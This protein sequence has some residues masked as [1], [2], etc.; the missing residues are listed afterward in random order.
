VTSGAEFFAVESALPELE[1]A[2]VMLGVQKTHGVSITRQTVEMVRLQKGRSALSAYEYQYYGLYRPELSW[3][4]KLAYVGG[5]RTR[6]LYLLAN[7][8][9]WWDA[10]E[11]KLAFHAAMQA[12]GYPTPKLHALMHPDRSFGG[13]ANLKDGAALVDWLKTA[14]TPLFGKPVNSNHGVGGVLIAS[15]DA[16]RAEFTTC[17]GKTHSLASLAEAV[18]PHMETGGYLFQ[19]ALVPH[20]DVARVTG[21]RLATLR[22]IVLR[23][24]DGPLVHHVIC[25][26]P[27]GANR[28]DNFRRPGNLIARVDPQ[29]GA[30]GP[31]IRGVGLNREVL[32]A[33]PDTGAGFVGANLP[34]VAD[35]VALALRASTGFPGL[36]MQSW[37]IAL[38]ADGVRAIEMNPGGNLN[39]VQLSNDSGAWT[40]ELQAFV[41]WCA[42][43]KMNTQIRGR[44][45]AVK[46]A[47]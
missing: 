39:L 29:T 12:Q 43:L 30:L 27:S 37:D 15:V 28:V 22:I 18:Q 38:C 9:T 44:D 35:A 34:L 3:D 26:M 11:D 33:H 5:E 6:A 40:P 19:E 16:G 23:G 21:D 17:A 8:F 36:H 13:V 46:I 42:D 7:E 4:D 14:P 25:R 31:V 2:K 47:A 41:R 1:Q 10:A 20:A 45:L 24:P 32:E